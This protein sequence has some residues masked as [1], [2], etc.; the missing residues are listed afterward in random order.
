MESLNFNLE[1]LDSKA[2]FQSTL[3][4]HLFTHKFILE[5]DVCGITHNYEKAAENYR[6]GLEY[7][8]NNMSSIKYYH[9]LGRCLVY[10][11]KR[12]EA[13]DAFDNC[14]KTTSRN[15]E[16][17]FAVLDSSAIE[18]NLRAFACECMALS[19]NAELWSA[20]VAPN[21]QECIRRYNHNL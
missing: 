5:A 12:N 8:P 15:K 7:A 19:L 10:M 18:E 2:I 1:Y 9:K 13:F 17:L 21:A 20:R 6:K 4:F 3:T 14:I 11:N 16:L